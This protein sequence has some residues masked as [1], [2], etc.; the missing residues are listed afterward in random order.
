MATK[1]VEQIENIFNRHRGNDKYTRRIKDK[2][3][4]RPNTRTET[5]Y[6]CIDKVGQI[7]TLVHMYYVQ[8]VCTRTWTNL[9]NK[10]L[11]KL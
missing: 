9:Y 7:G 6:I 1:N 10:T 4:M 5:G 3:Y 11:K 8:Y 2:H